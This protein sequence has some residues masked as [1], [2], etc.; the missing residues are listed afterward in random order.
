[1]TR[2]V[3]WD[4]IAPIV[5]SLQWVRR[6]FSNSLVLVV[7]IDLPRR[8]SWVHQGFLKTK[9]PPRFQISIRWSLLGHPPHHWW[10][11]WD[12]LIIVWW[13]TTHFRSDLNQKFCL[14]NPKLPQLLGAAGPLCSQCTAWLH[15]ARTWLVLQ[16]VVVK[17]WHSLNVE[18]LGKSPPSVHVC[19]GSRPVGVCNYGNGTTTPWRRHIVAGHRQ[20]GDVSWDVLWRP[21]GSPDR[22]YRAMLPRTVLMGYQIFGQWLQ[23]YPAPKSGLRAMIE[24][25]SFLSWLSAGYTAS[26]TQ[27]TV[28]LYEPL[29]RN[30]WFDYHEYFEV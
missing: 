30:S 3:I 24:L 4:A 19:P 16:R 5:T 21:P 17:V 9:T 20:N 6:H 1:M 15:R 29:F 26:Q 11:C 10:W 7:V 23:P 13:S 2:L 14:A 18:D 8:R 25:R 28:R 12:C 22:A 27:R